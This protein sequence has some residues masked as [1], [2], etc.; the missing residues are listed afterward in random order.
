MDENQNIEQKNLVIDDSTSQE[1]SESHSE[2]N[3]E[4]YSE[5]QS[6]FQMPS[7]SSGIISSGFEHRIFILPSNNSDESDNDDEDPLG[8]LIFQCTLSYYYQTQSLFRLLAVVVSLKNLQLFFG[9]L[10]DM[11]LELHVV[12]LN[13]KFIAFDDYFF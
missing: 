13:K 11:A 4:S 3:F 1:C 8:L 6:D 2:S 7:T 5:S 12:I 10:H 9:F